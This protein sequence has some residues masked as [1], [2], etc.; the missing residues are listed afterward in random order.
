MSISNNT[1]AIVGAGSVGSAAAYG[2]INQGLCDNV[3][4]L[5]KNYGKAKAE[6]TDLEN[7]IEFMGRNMHVKA[8]GY[9]ELYDT[10]IIVLTAAAPYVQ[11]QTRLDMLSDSV[12][13]VDDIVPKIMDSGFSGIFIVITNPVDI[14]SGYIR[15]ITGLPKNR[16]IGTGT[17]LDSARLKNVLSEIVN[18]DPRSIHAFSM[19]EHGDSQMIPWSVVRVGGKKWKDIIADNPDKFSA[20][21]PYE[22]IRKKIVGMGWDIIADKGST[23]YG[24]ASATLGIIKAIMHDENKIIPVSAMLEGEYGYNGI[25][26]GVPAVINKTGVKEIVEFKM[27]DEEKKQFDNSANIIQEFTRKIIK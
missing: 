11:G 26:A 14:I 4:L 1:V 17:S 12:K 18:V 10:D 23:N 27:T 21:F 6:A 13:I 20:D 22:K 25:Y 3:Y 24:I 7:S 5:D 9:E 19:G 16:V 2:I 8:A 15:K